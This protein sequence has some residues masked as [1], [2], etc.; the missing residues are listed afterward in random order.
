LQECHFALLGLQI[1]TLLA[2]RARPEPNQLRQSVAQA[3]RAWR[4]AF[5]SQLTYK[6]LWALL[7]NCTVDCYHRRMAKSCRRAPQKK[8]A[9]EIRP[10]KFRKLTNEIKERWA[11]T[12]GVTFAFNF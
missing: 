3:W 8:R 6:A 11:R 1:L 10:P 4:K 7:A 2:L 12:F 9:D 5:R